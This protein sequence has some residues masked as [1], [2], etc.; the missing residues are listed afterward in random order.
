VPPWL[1]TTQWRQRLEADPAHPMHLVTETGI[2][3][4]LNVDEDEAA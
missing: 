4:R 1:T 2:G 3:Y